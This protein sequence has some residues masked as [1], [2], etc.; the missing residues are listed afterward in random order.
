MEK[1]TKNFQ[2]ILIFGF[3][4]FK[5]KIYLEI[6]KKKRLLIDDS[7]KKNKHNIFFH[8]NINLLT[9][10]IFFSIDVKIF[11]LCFEKNGYFFKNILKG[12]NIFKINNLGSGSNLELILGILCNFWV[13]YKKELNLPFRSKVTHLIFISKEEREQLLLVLCYR[14]WFDR[15]VGRAFSND[16][17]LTWYGVTMI[18]NTR[19]FAVNYGVV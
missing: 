11:P 4:S 2:N 17:L 8:F 19:A 12:K 13:G 6:K 9:E 15:L 14:D 1:I 10:I 5:E 18:D 16:I 3:L 7:K